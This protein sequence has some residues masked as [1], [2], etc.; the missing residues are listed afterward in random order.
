MTSIIGLAASGLHANGY[1][2]VRALLAQFDLAL[3]RP[4]LERSSGRRSAKPK[5]SSWRATSRAN[6]LAT[7]GDVLLTP[8]RIYAQDVLALRDRLAADGT[9]PARHSPTSPAAA[10]PAMSRGRCP[11]ALGA[12][13]DPDAAGALSSVHAAGRRAWPAWT[14]AELRATLNGGLGMVAIVPAGRR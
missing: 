2:L 7:L 1:S 3:D 10:C 11:T 14:D 8:T 4:Y 6:A 9:P 5:P 13:L 12:R